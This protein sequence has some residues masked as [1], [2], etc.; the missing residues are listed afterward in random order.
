MKDC[1]SMTKQD[2]LAAQL[3]TCSR[4]NFATW[5]KTGAWAGRGAAVARGRTLAARFVRG[6]SGQALVITALSLTMLMGAMAMAI[7][8]GYLHYKQRQLQ[9]AADSAAIAAGLELTACGDTV[10]SPSM[11]TAAAQALVED[12]ISSSTIA[13]TQDACAVPA[14]SAASPLAM[15]INVHPCLV[16]N[17]PNNT[18][19]NTHM[20]EVVLAER[21]TTFFGAILG[22]PTVT[23]VAR[24]EAG[25]AYINNAPSPDYCLRANSIEFNSNNGAFNLTNCGA[26]D[27]GNLQT[28]SGDSVTATDFLYQGTWSPNNCNGSCVW[29]L[30]DS[31]TQPTPTTVTPPDPLASL[32]EPTA[33]P[34]VDSGNCSI[35]NMDCSGNTLTK[36]QQNGTAAVN[37]PPGTYGGGINVNSGMTLNLSPGLYY[38]NGSFVVNS[39]GATVECTSCSNGGAGV[40]LFFENGSFQPNSSATV[41]L[42]APATGST[43]NNDVA[44]MLIWESK[45][46]STSMDMDAGTTITL[47]GIIYLPSAELDLN[48][49]SGTTINAKATAT[50]ID[51][52]DLRVNSGVTLD[53]TGSQSLLPS[54]PS[55]SLSPNFALAE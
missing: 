1:K 21:Q 43:S 10:C 19:A 17:D 7:D 2:I 41:T 37:L 3:K 53:L 51:V 12:G 22:I 36:A 5:S 20:A 26:Y 44:N 40:T 50:A 4:V 31:E 33:P 30:G 48:S 11:T 46:N 6:E 52:N 38:F 54:T 39:G 45:N 27:K 29:N 14:V 8:V 18:L 35:S 16:A 49:G 25:N 9:T 24:A 15:G 42:N 55:Q 34:T 23:I 13:P 28:D 47:N 32:T